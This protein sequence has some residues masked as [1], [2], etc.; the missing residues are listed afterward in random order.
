MNFI[1]K[2]YYDEI[3]ENL[4]ISNQTI[5]SIEFDDCSF[6]NCIFNTSI[7]QHCKFT[8]CTFENC[9][10]SLMKPKGSVFNDIKISNSKAIGINWT[11]CN[12]P[13]EVNFES[14]DISM[15]SFYEL[16]LRHTK[17]ISCKAND[18]DFG[19]TNLEKVNFKDTDLKGT[20][21]GDTN[22]KDTDLRFAINYLIDPQNNFLKG[23]KVSLPQANSFLEFLDIKIT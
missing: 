23:T 9:N 5:K 19:K 4:N 22:L 6:K 15:S 21:F 16:D 20:I 7:L 13:F 2:E 8:E 10:L 18:I 1:K 12:K 14:S 17:I 3:F 11:L